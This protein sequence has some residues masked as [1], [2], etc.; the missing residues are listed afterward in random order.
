MIKFLKNL[1]LKF[2]SKDAAGA[3]DSLTKTK[4]VRKVLALSITAVIIITLC[5]ALVTGSISFE[6]FMQ[7]V[8]E[9]QP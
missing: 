5:Y 8:Q 4:R 3:V 7:G 9:V 1:K 2:D 6:Q